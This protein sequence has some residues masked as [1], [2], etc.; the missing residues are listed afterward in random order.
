MGS[1]KHVQDN[2]DPK[3]RFLVGVTEIVG[4]LV[5]PCVPSILKGEQEA[6][7]DVTIASAL[8]KQTAVAVTDKLGR[9]PVCWVH[10]Q[11]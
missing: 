10:L 6:P 2:E 5:L 9:V 7:P 1:P 3:V 4:E 11:P 8:A